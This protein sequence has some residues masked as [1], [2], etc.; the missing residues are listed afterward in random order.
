MKTILSFTCRLEEPIIEFSDG[1]N[2]SWLYNW[3]TL[4]A[5]VHL[6]TLLSSF[7]SRDQTE[8]EALV[9]GD[10]PTHRIIWWVW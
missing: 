9:N 3:N 1:N 7:S 10:L 6:A 8:K 4:L 5:E 2:F